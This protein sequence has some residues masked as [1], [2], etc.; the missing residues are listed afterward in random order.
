MTPSRPATNAKS[1]LPCLSNSV[2]AVGRSKTTKV[3]PPSPVDW[4][5]VARPTSLKARFGA[6]VATVTSSP[7]L[8]SSLSAVAAS[9]AISSS[10][11]G[12]RPLVKPIGAN[13]GGM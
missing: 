12:G 3:A 11:F 4:P 10:P 9:S 5:M 2:W 13:G 1:T 8:K 7:S 6:L